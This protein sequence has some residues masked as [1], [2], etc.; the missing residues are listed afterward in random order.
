MTKRRK[1]EDQDKLPGTSTRRKQGTVE[2]HANADIRALKQAGV[3]PEGTEALQSVYRQLARTF[4]DAARNGET[5]WKVTSGRE[6]LRVR[7]ALAPITPR[8][9]GVTIEEILDAIPE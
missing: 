2:R 7:E 8:T 1:T 5:H 3:V 9:G 4:D 6:M